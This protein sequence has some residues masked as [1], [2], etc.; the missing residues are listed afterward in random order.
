[1][2][3][4]VVQPGE[5]PGTYRSHLTKSLENAASRDHGPRFIPGEDVVCLP[6][7][8]KNRGARSYL[9]I[10]IASAMTYPVPLVQRLTPTT[11]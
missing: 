1:M 5:R 2:R 3:C 11:L 10:R 7:V 8:P 9:R 6:K 4:R